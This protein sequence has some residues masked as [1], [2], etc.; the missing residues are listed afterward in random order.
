MVVSRRAQVVDQ[1][2][3]RRARRRPHPKRAGAAPLLAIPVGN[4]SVDAE[5]TTGLAANGHM[6]MVGETGEESP[7]AANP[8]A[9]RPFHWV[10]VEEAVAKCV[11]KPREGV[12]LRGEW[13]VP[14][15]SGAGL[16]ASQ[17]EKVVAPR[18]MGHHP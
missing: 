7:F 8:R 1:V 3:Q 14:F 18:P 2:C 4:R 17:R 9:T 16:R 5:A 13:V 10:A 15:S 12:G 6:M 11:S